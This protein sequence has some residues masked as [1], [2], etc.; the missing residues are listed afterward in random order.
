MVVSRR[1]RKNRSPRATRSSWSIL[2]PLALPFVILGGLAVYGVLAPEPQHSL[3]SPGR[4]GAL[5][6][7]DGIFAS[8]AELK[9]WIRLHGGSYREWL[10]LHPSASRL[11]A[12]GTASPRAD[13]VQVPVSAAEKPHLRAAG[14]RA[15]AARVGN[16]QERPGKDWSLW[17]AVTGIAALATTVLV[18]VAFR[19]PR[20]R[21]PGLA[22][23]AARAGPH[24]TAGGVPRSPTPEPV[25]APDVE[26]N[27]DARRNEPARAEPRVESCVIVWW[28]GYVKSQFQAAT[29]EGEVIS[30]SPFFSW[31]HSDP[32]PESVPFSEHLAAL[33]GTLE[34]RGWTPLEARDHW[35]AVRFER[36]APYAD[37]MLL[38]AMDF[39]VARAR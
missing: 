8:K 27:P 12:R 17:Y 21:R 3:P 14:K 19:L 13:H 28:R 24:A 4:Q 10:E 5:V 16:S 38:P 15:S 6:W 22:P 7:G 37:T 2:L 20:R 11:L 18:G 34:D 35:F 1:S 39:E 33:F 30:A 32:P 25:R 36:P 29:S 31:R 9:A 26:P 23:T